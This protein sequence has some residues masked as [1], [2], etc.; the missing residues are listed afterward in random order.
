MKPKEIFIKAVVLL[1]YVVYSVLCG[2]AIVAT[3]VFTMNWLFGTT[4]DSLIIAF[5]CVGVLWGLQIFFWKFRNFRKVV[6]SI[7]VLGWWFVSPN[8]AFLVALILAGGLVAVFATIIERM[9]T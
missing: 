8:I 5:S 9:L 1:W 3:S 2:Y 7:H 6:E 4:P